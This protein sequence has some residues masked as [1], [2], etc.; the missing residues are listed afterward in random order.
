MVEWLTLLLQVQILAQSGYPDWHFA[1][2]SPV[3]PAKYAGKVPSIRPLPLPSTSFPI[4]HSSYYLMLHSLTA[5]LSKPQII[6]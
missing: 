5:L 6:K 2:S 1:W 3:P 4:H